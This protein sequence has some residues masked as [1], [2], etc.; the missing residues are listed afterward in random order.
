MSHFSV[1]VLTNSCVGPDEALAPFNENLEVD[2]YIRMTREEALK[3]VNWYRE[4]LIKKDPDKFQNM[5]DNAFLEYAFDGSVDKDFNILSTMNPNGK[6]DWY[7][8][9]KGRWGS[10][11]IPRKAEFGGQ[12]CLSCLVKEIAFEPNN[13]DYKKALEFWEKNVEHATDESGKALYYRENYKDAESYALCCS[14]FSTYA[15]ITPD[16]VWHEAGKM[17]WFAMSSASP[18]DKQKWASEY[19]SLVS[20]YPDATATFV[21]CH[22]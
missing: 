20:Q 1:L 7:S 10:S 8:I 22:I 14:K 15:V 9:E 4:D 3:S 5:S 2:R 19:E 21:D 11:P 17:G 13:D 18:E 16:G 6:W 12:G